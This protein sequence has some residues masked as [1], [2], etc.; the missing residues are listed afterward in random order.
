MDN[1]DIENLGSGN[2]DPA[3]LA[4]LYVQKGIEMA[5]TK[6]TAST[7][8]MYKTFEDAVESIK[9]IEDTNV[10][11]KV[12]SE[13]AVLIA[14]KTGLSSEPIKFASQIGASPLRD[15]P[16]HDETFHRMLMIALS[17]GVLKY[18]AD[19]A[20]KIH[21]QAHRAA[22]KAY[23]AR[24]MAE[25]DAFGLKDK[26]DTLLGDAV[27]DE[28]IGKILRG[29]SAK[30]SEFLGH[31]DSEIRA[32]IAII[33]A[34]IR[35]LGDGEKIAKTIVEE[36][37]RI[38]ALKEIYEIWRQSLQDSI[39]RARKFRNTESITSSVSFLW[40]TADKQ[41]QLG[42]EDD[43]IK[44][45]QELIEVEGAASQSERTKDYSNREGRWFTV[46]NVREKI[47]EIR[48]NMDKKEL[49]QDKGIRIIKKEHAGTTNGAIRKAM[50]KNF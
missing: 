23:V 18:A 25:K 26:I 37:P 14:E 3:H 19:F 11:K 16:L 20:E 13:N 9:K 49:I 29:D 27:I 45:L 30:M 34:K 36:A 15:Y 47:N 21:D 46:D 41:I 7:P 38:E 39:N 1:H 12:F 43:A 44:T 31:K 33:T 32:N 40:D 22:A 35:S 5:N 8:A 6:S 24:K 17:K 48:L 28:L 50:D 4:E 10:R 42:F 2:R